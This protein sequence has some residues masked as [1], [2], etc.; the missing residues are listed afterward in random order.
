LKI[1]ETVRKELPATFAISKALDDPF[2]GACCAL[3]GRTM[4]TI[5]LGEEYHEPPKT[6]EMEELESAIIDHEK[7]TSREGT[8]AGIDEEIEGGDTTNSWGAWGKPQNEEGVGW[9]SDA[10]D[11]GWGSTSGGN[12]SLGGELE[13][14]WNLA[15]VPTLTELLGPTKL[16][17]THTT[18]I[19][20]VSMRKIVDLI[21]PSSIG[22]VEGSTPDSPAGVVEEELYERFA[23]IVLGPWIG[24]DC[25]KETIVDKPTISPRSRGPVK[26]EGE[27]NQ[28]VEG[29]HDP[30][31]ENITVLVEPSALETMIIGVG[32]SAIWVQITRADDDGNPVGG[33]RDV[34]YMESVTQV[35]PS[36]YLA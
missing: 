2:S 8:W 36:F 4:Q 27:G 35:I 29:A 21:H 32:I 5:D 25:G 28:G 23:R 16:P 17:L 12:H 30:Y 1:L 11:G 10:A 34:W 9:G 20:E 26:A 14:G 6:Q 15:P 31:K 13:S 24:W 22:K 19:F 3:W 7:I 33:G 18:G